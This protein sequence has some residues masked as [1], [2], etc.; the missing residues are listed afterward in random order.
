[1]T[2]DT[3]Q[4]PRILVSEIAY[5]RLKDSFTQ[6]LPFP[7]KFNKQKLQNFFKELHSQIQILK[8]SYQENLKGNDVTKWIF[9]KCKEIY[10]HV[11]EHLKKPD[12]ITKQVASLRWA[13]QV[14]L[15]F[16]ERLDLP[17][18]PKLLGTGIDH[19][20]VVV[21]SAEPLPK[22]K[23][24]LC[25]VSTSVDDFQVTTNIQSV[26]RGDV[27][28][29]ALVPPAMVGGVISE[30]MFEGTKV[31]QGLDVGDYLPYERSI[32]DVEAVLREELRQITKKK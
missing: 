8:W 5:H 3:S 31:P 12:Q 13:L 27:M 2:I 28:P 15:R 30:A 32:P 18:N 22:T 21:K 11:G 10:E 16:P 29:L 6:K 24:L 1:M 4:D 19:I 7:A 26:K 9:S 23:L 20:V 14:F 17:H 25:K